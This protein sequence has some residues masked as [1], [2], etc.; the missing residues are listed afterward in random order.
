MSYMIENALYRS[1]KRKSKTIRLDEES[2][3]FRREVTAN[4]LEWAV[5]L[6]SKGFTSSKVTKK[7]LAMAK[8]RLR[9][10]LFKSQSWLRLQVTTPE[11]DLVLKRKIVAK[12]FVRFKAE[13]SA[14]TVTDEE[15][16]SYFEANRLKFGNMPFSNFKKNI[17]VFLGRKQM[18][19]RLRD[20][21]Q[22]L[23]SK[24]KVRNFLM[25]I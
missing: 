12:R 15:A 17:K 1:K 2:K 6:E 13:S 11:I 23:Q 18:D 4:L 7:E 8:V 16:L 24:Y 9:N 25:E 10:G 3:P 19:R 22:V 5:Y 14:V 20:W 21:F